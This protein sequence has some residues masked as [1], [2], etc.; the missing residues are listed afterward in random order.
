MDGYISRDLLYQKIHPLRDEAFGADCL[1]SFKILKIVT[2][3]LKEWIL[4]MLSKIVIRCKNCQILIHSP[5]IVKSLHLLSKFGS[6]IFNGFG[7]K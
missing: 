4:V 7:E 5:L 2:V 3:S 1:A 6:C